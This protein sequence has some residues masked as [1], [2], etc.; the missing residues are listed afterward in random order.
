MLSK[1]Y[2]HIR[3]PIVMLLRVFINFLIGQ[4]GKWGLVIGR[5][6]MGLV[7]MGGLR[8]LF[9][10]YELIVVVLQRFIFVILCYE[11]M[12]LSYPVLGEFGRSKGQRRWVWIF[13]VGVVLVSVY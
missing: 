10:M 8:R 9:F 13:V 2:H 12:G 11:I 4:V 1:F 3:T 7:R 5:A 6:R